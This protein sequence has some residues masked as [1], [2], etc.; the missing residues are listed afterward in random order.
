[1]TIVFY[2]KGDLKFEVHG[3]SEEDLT[4]LVSQFNDGHLIRIKALFINPN[5]LISYIAYE[6]EEN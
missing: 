1:M 4:R 2:L 5:E 6:V 3:C